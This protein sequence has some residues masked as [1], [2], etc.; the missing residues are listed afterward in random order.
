MNVAETI[1]ERLAES[2]VE[3]LFLMPG[4]AFPILEA[5]VG[6][7][8]R[9][10]NVPRIV[11]CPH[12]IVAVAAAHGHFMLTGQPQAVL[13]HTDVGLQMAGGMLH[14]ADRGRAGLV[15]LANEAPRTSRGEA[16]GPRVV[17]VHWMQDRQD[18]AGVVRDYVRW[19]YRLDRPEVVLS[20]LNRALQVAQGPPAGPVYLQLVRELLFDEMPARLLESPPPRAAPP[21]LGVLGPEAEDRL[22]QDL[23]SARNPLLIT[24]HAGR[25][26][27]GFQAV[28]DFSRITGVPVLSTNE[29]TNIPWDHP[30]RVVDS[31][32]ALSEADLILLVDVDVPY[33]PLFGEPS[34]DCV[35][36]QL[37]ED[38]LKSRIS[39]W[40]FP[41]TYSYQVDAATSLERLLSREDLPRADAATQHPESNQ[42]SS[43][44]PPV[45]DAAE[46]ITPASLAA[47]LDRVL[48]ESAVIIDDSNTSNE[49]FASTLRLGQ[50]KSYFRPQG[51]SMGWGPGAALGAKLAAPDRL[52][53]SVNGDGNM[54]SGVCEA[55]LWASR[56]HAA[57]FLTVVCNNRQYAAIKLG[58][59]AA[60]PEGA[61]VTQGRYPGLEF[62][63]PPRFDEIAKACGIHGERVSD[64]DQLHDALDRGIRQVRNGTGALVD[65]LVT[66][67]R[68]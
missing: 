6:L 21:T 29:R 64:P 49:V 68:L 63:N 8:G 39:L 61:M 35:V 24:G 60:F 56:E 15:I 42:R 50:P 32:A 20:A 11:T 59:Q 10:R 36:Y 57:P 65:V 47:A 14:N 67:P 46:S 16:P 1:V 19:S 45:H 23:S 66:P 37:D 12:E 5:I 18:Q 26:A 48:D 25:T 58:V 3:Y 52:V 55:A 41:V 2:G 51:S 27:T 17:P 30:H 62:P 4:D 44:E 54:I 53:V 31:G 22:V 34:N 40:D 38:P 9:S 28:S 33:I 43:Q 13:L 7:E